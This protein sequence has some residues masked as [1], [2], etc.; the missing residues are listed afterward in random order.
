MR[1]RGHQ[2]PRLWAFALL[3][4]T[5]SLFAAATPHGAYA[6]GA[7]CTGAAIPNNGRAYALGQE[8]LPSGPADGVKGTISWG[9]PNVCTTP[10]GNAFSLEAVSLCNSGTACTGWVQP[11][12]RKD[13][14]NSVPHLV[15]EF[16]N[17]GGQ[18]FIMTAPITSAGH[19]YEMSYDPLDQLWDCYLDGV[20]KYSRGNLG[21]TSGNF[22]NGQGETNA[23]YAEI[24]NVTP[25]YIQ[26]SVMKFRRSVAYSGMDLTSFFA[27][28]CAPGCVATSR[29]GVL[30]NAVSS[31]RNWT[32]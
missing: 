3:A 1:S 28:E 13:Q 11:G 19:I 21:F 9:N 27:G 18:N 16:H 10:A 20:N 7:Q 5:L 22:V 29:Y 30:E 6:A 15:C 25:S 14:A 2:P 24:G 12:W 8:D 32:N 4:T 23:R 31:M 26:Y 17:T